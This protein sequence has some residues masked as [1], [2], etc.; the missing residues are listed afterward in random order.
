MKTQVLRGKLEPLGLVKVLA[1][2]ANLKES[3]YLKVRLAEIEKTLIIKDGAIIFAKSNLPEDRLGDIL[4]NQDKITSSQYEAASK[5]LLEKGF[6]HGRSL[7]EIKAITPKQLWEAIEDQIKMIAYSVVPWDEGEFEF[8]KQALNVK[9]KITLRLSIVDLVTDVVRHF[10]KRELFLQKFPDLGA[11]PSVV[12]V[13]SDAIHLQIHEK[14]VLGLIDGQ[15]DL[16]SIC[17][18]A[19]F[20]LEEGLRTI[21]LLQILGVIEVALHQSDKTM[22]AC[23]QII[24]KYNEIFQYVH[25]FL[26]QQMGHVAHNLL[27]KYYHD[28]QKTQKAVFG[29]LDLKQDGSLDVDRILL[30]LQKAPLEPNAIESALQEAMQ[31]YL[32]ASILAIAR[33]LGNEQETLA[34]KHIE[35]MQDK[36]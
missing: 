12:D 8:V 30:N 17:E 7:V 21:F 36:W 34:V 9:E 31:E 6:R 3:G 28:V 29:G 15:R 4:L 11:I 2:I 14:H 32:Y 5:L 22:Q 13:P 25:Q 1:Y 10:D 24:S 26:A 33:A 23:K 19:D 16:Q 27:R 20:G 18:Q 35:A